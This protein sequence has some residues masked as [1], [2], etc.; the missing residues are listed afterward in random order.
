MQLT[1]LN[2]ST[3]TLQSVISKLEKC[4]A[5]LRDGSPQMTLLEKRLKAFDLSISLITFYKNLLTEQ[6][7]LTADLEVMKNDGKEKTVRYREM[8][9]QKLMNKT[10]IESIQRYVKHN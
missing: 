10:M 9:G 5:K 8:L 6:E 7:K 3:K 4:A 1:E 2:E